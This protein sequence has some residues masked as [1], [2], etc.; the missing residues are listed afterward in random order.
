M[1]SP[2]LSLARRVLNATARLLVVLGSPLEA[3]RL[4]RGGSFS[5]TYS[6]Q[7]ALVRRQL[8]V[9]V[10]LLAAVLLVDFRLALAFLAA[11]AVV[12]LGCAWTGR[13]SR[14]RKHRWP[15][16]SLRFTA[17][18]AYDPDH[19]AHG[20]RRYGSIFKTTAL[21]APMV[22]IADLELGRSVLHTHARAL[23]SRRFRCDAIVPKGMLRWMSADDHERYRAVFLRAFTPELMRR[24]ADSFDVAFNRAFAEMA[25]VEAP[26]D[27]VPFMRDAAREALA[28]VLV[29][30]GA[31]NRRAYELLPYVNNNNPLDAT[32]AQMAEAASELEA[33]VRAVAPGTVSVAGAI[34]ADERDGLKRPDDHSQLDRACQ[35][36]RR[37]R[38]RPIDLDAQT[39]CRPSGVDE[40]SSRRDR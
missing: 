19:Y 8:L 14:G 38:H 11:V 6:A 20:V 9:G 18:A 3:M 16:G 29:G 21:H 33:I 12:R 36:V 26:T 5:T 34:A 15:P 27:P 25:R 35:D 2:A 13:E 4:L 1:V 24:C 28:G 23:R 17:R 39:P 7:R 40:P 10:A 30:L 31:E 32:D 22:C 37:R